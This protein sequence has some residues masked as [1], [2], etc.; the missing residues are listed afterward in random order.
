MNRFVLLLLFISA[1]CKADDLPLLASDASLDIVFEFPLEI[2]LE[3]AADRP[4]VD[5]FLYYIN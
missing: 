5:G 2:I 3:Q 1:C 4:V